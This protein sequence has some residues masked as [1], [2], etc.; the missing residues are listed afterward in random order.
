MP[1]WLMPGLAEGF[2][3]AIVKLFGHAEMGRFV[4][5]IPDVLFATGL[6]GLMQTSLA[7]A[8]LL[9]RR[10][11]NPDVH[12]MTHDGYIARSIIFGAYALFATICAFAAFQNGARADV[13]AN[14]FIVAVLPIFATAIYGAVISRKERLDRYQLCGLGIALIGALL[15]TMPALRPG[16]SPL[17]IAYSFGTMLGATATRLAAQDIRAWG[18]LS[19]LPELNP[20][21]M[22]LWGGAVLA[23]ALPLSLLW[24][25]LR[26]IPPQL[27][28]LGFL[29][30]A[31]VT[32]GGQAIWWTC[33]LYA[34]PKD[35]TPLCIKELGAGTLYLAT[36]TFGGALF[37]GDALPPAKLFGLALFLPAFFLAQKQAREYCRN[38]FFGVRPVSSM[39]ATEIKIPATVH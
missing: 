5:T 22:Q 19:K 29:G 2:F 4:P 38:R 31:M 36:A 18:K 13:G 12:I 37:A 17:W 6:V 24:I 32:A 20:W 28:V 26:G 39:P 34:V 10:R 30:A 16:N 14:T 1:E 3:M 35:G 21:V 8:V 9:A 25:D 15:V 11:R 33:R 7:L 27:I 23:L